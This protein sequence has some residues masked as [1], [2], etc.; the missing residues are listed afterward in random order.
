MDGILQVL[1]QQ[2]QQQ[3]LWMQRLQTMIADQNAATSQTMQQMLQIVQASSTRTAAS[4]S[5]ATSR[6][7]T[8]D[9]TE[10]KS[11]IDPKFIE[12]CPRFGGENE[13]FPEWS[14]NMES[15]AG[16]LASRTAC[17]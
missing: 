11:I 16:S 6:T 14:L 8:N 1:Q 4:S 10:I 7:I 5:A 3:Q 12:K 15:H 13:D 17:A 2:Q 9:M